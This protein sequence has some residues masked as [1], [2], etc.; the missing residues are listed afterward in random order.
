MSDMKP[1]DYRLIT[2]PPSDHQRITE[3]CYCCVISAA[4]LTDNS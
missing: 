4:G 1:H 3:L 2:Q